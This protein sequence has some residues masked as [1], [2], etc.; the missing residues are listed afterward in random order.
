MARVLQNCCRW[1]R[2][3]RE[4]LVMEGSWRVCNVPLI[5]CRRSYQPFLPSGWFIPSP[6]LRLSRR[7]L[8]PGFRTAVCRTHPPSKLRWSYGGLTVYSRGL[9]TRVGICTGRGFP[10]KKNVPSGWYIQSDNV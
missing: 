2:I 7:V 9:D 10:I 8:V 1:P 3:A 6:E 5:L 4:T